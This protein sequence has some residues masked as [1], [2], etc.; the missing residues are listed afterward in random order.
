[1]KYSSQDSKLLTS[2]K[3]LESPTLFMYQQERKSINQFIG[4]ISKRLN[5]VIVQRNSISDIIIYDTIS[6]VT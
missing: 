2:T 1:M 4:K 3:G 6:T 5:Q